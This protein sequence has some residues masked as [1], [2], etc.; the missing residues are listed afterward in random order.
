MNCHASVQGYFKIMC[1]GE[2]MRKIKYIHKNI[3]LY[4]MNLIRVV[5]TKI[6]ARAFKDHVLLNMH[7]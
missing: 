7:V 6:N 4:T 3:L 1:S 2:Y 5:Y